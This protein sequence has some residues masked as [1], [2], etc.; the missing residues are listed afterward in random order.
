MTAY[1]REV[2][3]MYSTTLQDADVTAGL[4]YDIP[5]LPLHPQAVTS[6]RGPRRI[7]DRGVLTS[8]GVCTGG[9]LKIYTTHI[10]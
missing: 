3:P 6:G 9:S 5:T 2:N 4:K 10:Y 7:E 1:N 8:H